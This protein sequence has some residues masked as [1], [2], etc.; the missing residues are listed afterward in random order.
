M[1]ELRR[2]FPAKG[3]TEPDVAGHDDEH[4]NSVP[5]SEREQSAEPPEVATPD[6]ASPTGAAGRP[7]R[8]R[9]DLRTA[10]ESVLNTR[11][12]PGE[13]GLRWKRFCDLVRDQ[14]NKS[15]TD[16]GYGDKTIRRA[17]D[18]IKAV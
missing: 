18:A 13:G 2:R 12:K 7:T 8:M 15:P 16:W 5:P 3:R 1:T 4:A 9:P 10:I 6:A 14:C 17:V 11:G